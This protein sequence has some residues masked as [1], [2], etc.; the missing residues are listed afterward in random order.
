M[1]YLTNLRNTPK[2]ASYI[3][4]L[5]V[6][7]LESLAT[8]LSAYFTMLKVKSPI[9][10]NDTRLTLSKFI[11]SARIIKKR[12]KTGRARLEL[13]SSGSSI[14]REQFSVCSYRHFEKLYLGNDWSFLAGDDHLHCA[15]VN[16]KKLQFIEYVEGDVI[17]FTSPTLSIFEKEQADLIEKLNPKP[18]LVATFIHDGDQRLQAMEDFFSN[19][20]AE[21][22]TIVYT[23]MDAFTEGVY[24]GGLW[25]F[26]KISNNGFYMTLRS[27]KQFK[28]DINTNGFSGTMSAD[29]A[30]IIC[31]LFALC[32]LIQKYN[33][34]KL[35]DLYDH[36]VAFAY[37][38]NESHLIVMAID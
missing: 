17:I 2:P 13:T 20:A 37:E 33:S 23:F 36:L 25:D 29:A 21:F 3:S 26:C 22:Q 18:R 4:D 31:N 24:D 7:Q 1:H 6:N 15:F 34:E 10:D 8:E 32:Y 38:H 19:R 16:A 28:I 12:L 5:N 35:M 11:K 9:R 27:E 30:S 14:K